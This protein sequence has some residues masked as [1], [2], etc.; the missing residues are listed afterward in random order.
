MST[1]QPSHGRSAKVAAPMRRSLGALPP[2]IWALGVVSLLMDTSSELVHSLLPVFL[3][4]IL[5]ASL[6]AIGVVEGIAEATASATKV[7]SGIA[8]DA[9]GRRK[10]LVVL[11]YGLGA[12]SKPGFPLARSVLEVFAAR[13]VDRIG[14]GIRGAPRDALV[15]DLAPPA[16]RGAAYGLRQ[17]LD[18]VGAFLGPLLAVVF[19]ARFADDLEAVLWVAVAPAFASV[20]LLAIAVREPPRDETDRDGAPPFRLAGVRRLEPR[21]WRVVGL[22]AVFTLARFSEPFLVL[23][24]Q[25]SGLGIRYVPTV[26]IAMNLF[27]AGGAYPAGVAADRMSRRTLLVAGLAVL[28]LAD[29]VLAGAA[30]PWQV[31]VGA[32]LWGVHMALTQGLLSKLVADTASAEL[33][34]TAFGIFNL[35]SG[36]ALL[37]ASVLA[38]ALWEHVGPAATFLAGALFAALAAVG[39]VAFAPRPR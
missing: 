15:A 6:V 39:V 12:L 4:D 13:F 32:S 18:S 19:M 33:R 10:L 7:V 37:I 38:G 35:V 9:L 36:A 31:F 2:S 27:Y 30:A 26:M 20:A 5:G 28:V 23:R 17:A 11:G 25:S 1:G 16:L 3:K 29:G 22:G 24:A 14:K 21:F 34:A 8:S